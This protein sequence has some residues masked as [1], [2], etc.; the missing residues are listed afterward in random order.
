MTL[1]DNAAVFPSG[2]DAVT[3]IV[4]FPVVSSYGVLYVPSSRTFAVTDGGLGGGA[5][6]ALLPPGAPD[7]PT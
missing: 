1:R 2:P 5:G 4:H 6:V 3:V 7:G